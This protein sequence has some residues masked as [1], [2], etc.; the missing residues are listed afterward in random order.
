MEVSKF[1]SKGRV[2][3]LSWIHPATKSTLTRCSQPLVGALTRS[4]EYDEAMVSAIRTASPGSSTLFIMDARP[5]INAYGNQMMG[6]GFELASKYPNTRLEFMDIGKP[7]LRC[8]C[9]VLGADVR[10]CRNMHR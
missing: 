10:L 4:C 6:A 7:Q 3:V 2:P 8:E 1:R 9:V 5:R